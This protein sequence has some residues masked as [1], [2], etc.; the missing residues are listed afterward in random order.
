MLREFEHIGLLRKAINAKF[1]Y[2]SGIFEKQWGIF[3]PDWAKKFDEE[4]KVFFQDDKPRIEHAARG[5]GAFCLDSM[6]LQVRFNKT[7][8][9]E[10]KT[11]EE[12]ASEVYQN[13]T[14][15]FDLY[16]PGILISHYLWKHHYSQQLFFRD[17]LVPLLNELREFTFFDVG[18]G[19]GFYSK[20]ILRVFPFSSGEGF[21]MSPHSLEHTKLLLHRWNFQKRYKTNLGDILKRKGGTDCDLVISIEVLEHLEDPLGFLKGLW[22]M[23][24]SGGLGFIS[25]AVNAPNA[26]HIYLYRSAD[27]VASQLKE[28]GFSIVNSIEDTAYEPRSG[29]D[30]VP[31]NAAFIVR[32]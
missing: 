22:S 5:Y 31:L 1:P 16:L 20:E 11:Y 15:M 23:L 17:E 12:A 26:D 19:T 9:Y 14:Y 27:E 7:K 4:L 2:L 21:D 28:A 18:V 10:F 32:K 25:A 6:K 8:E 29:T 13:K 30:I 3:G 24:K